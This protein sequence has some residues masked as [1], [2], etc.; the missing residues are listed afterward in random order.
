MEPKSLEVPSDEASA[1]RKDKKLVKSFH[2]VLY[3]T[4][5]RDRISI[6]MKSSPPQLLVGTMPGLIVGIGIL[7]SLEL[8][9]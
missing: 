6:Y 2:D 7:W 5:H 3:N 8:G 9:V 1:Y 4:I